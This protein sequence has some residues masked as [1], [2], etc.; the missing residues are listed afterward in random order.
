MSEPPQACSEDCCAKHKLIANLNGR[1]ILVPL[2]SVLI[3]GELLGC[4]ATTVFELGYINPTLENPLECA[5]VFP[6]N[7][8]NFIMC[9]FEATIGETKMVTK[10]QEKQKAKEKYEDAIASGNTTVLATHSSRKA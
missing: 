7:A 8:S 3:K 6:D 1:E 10:I 5:F 2:K 4:L 9:D